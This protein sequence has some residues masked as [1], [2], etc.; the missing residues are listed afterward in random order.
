MNRDPIFYFTFHKKTAFFPLKYIYP[1]CF[2]H[3]KD[4]P[5]LIPIACFLSD[6][7]P[8]GVNCGEILVKRVHYLFDNVVP[9]SEMLLAYYKY[10][11]RPKS[12][13]CAVFTKDLDPPKLYTVNPFAFKKFQREGTTYSWVPPDEYTYM[14][15]SKGLISIDNLVRK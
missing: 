9:E 14:G 1:E 4:S 10:K 13:R 5:Q 11:D 6:S 15:G 7:C 2:F 12:I 8:A 3:I